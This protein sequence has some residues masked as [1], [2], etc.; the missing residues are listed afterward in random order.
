V[1]NDDLIFR[2]R[3]RL[4]ARAGEIELGYHRSW[5]Y[6]WYGQQYGLFLADSEQNGRHPRLLLL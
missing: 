5:Y 1:T 4:F 2:H 6:R 3:V